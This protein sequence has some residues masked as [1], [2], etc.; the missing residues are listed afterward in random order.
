MT[1]NKV[2][3]TGLLYGKMGNH[4]TKGI[5]CCPHGD[6]KFVKTVNKIAE[7]NPSALKISIDNTTSNKILIE[8][9]ELPQLSL[10]EKIL[11]RVDKSQRKALELRKRGKIDSFVYKINEFEYNKLK[12]DYIFISKKTLDKFSENIKKAAPQE[13]QEYLKHFFY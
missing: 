4:L 12:T 1:T 8:T 7:T 10:F 3:F 6:A 5:I 2:A 13:L 11:Y 9:K